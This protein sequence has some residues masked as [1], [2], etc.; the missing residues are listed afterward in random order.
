MISHHGSDAQRV[1]KMTRV[2]T[3]RVAPEPVSEA[4][5]ILQTLFRFNI[6]LSTTSGPEPTLMRAI[7]VLEEIV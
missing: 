4:K 2:N 1:P 3:E 6:A 5:D 7:G